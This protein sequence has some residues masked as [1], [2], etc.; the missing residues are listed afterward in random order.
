MSTEEALREQFRSFSAKLDAEKQEIRHLENG[1]GG[2]DN[3]GMDRRIT[4][5]E[6]DM[7]AVKETLTG[8]QVTLAEIKASIATKDDISKLDI[9][10]NTIEHTMATSESLAAS[11][12]RLAV[13]DERTTKLLTTR[14]AGV[15]MALAIGAITLV[16]RWH[17]I[18]SSF[19][20]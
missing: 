5:L 19:H 13:L 6:S 15:M 2:N 17:D 1:S 12:T 4:N 7:K 3:G 10:L 20:R 11:N 16:T 18:L 9:R 8:I 14:S